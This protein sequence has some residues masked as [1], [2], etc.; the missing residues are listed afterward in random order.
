M[1]PEDIDKILKRFEL[2]S[3]SKGFPSPMEASYNFIC[4]LYRGEN[5]ITLMEGIP[6]NVDNVYVWEDVDGNLFRH[7]D[8]DYETVIASKKNTENTNYKLDWNA[9]TSFKDI[10][11]FVKNVDVHLKL[12][13]ND[14]NKISK[15]MKKVQK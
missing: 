3:Y 5:K 6:K 8:F 1:N 13:C 11:N 12:S 10:V 4:V 9:I 15:V 2:T 7:S 14:V